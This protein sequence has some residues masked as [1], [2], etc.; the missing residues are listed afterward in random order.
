MNSAKQLTSLIMTVNSD[1]GNV[2]VYIQERSNRLRVIVGLR[3][4]MAALQA[5]AAVLRAG[6]GFLVM[7][8]QINA[9]LWCPAPLIEILTH[10]LAPAV[11]GPLSIVAYLIL[12]W[13]GACCECAHCLNNYT[14]LMD[15]GRDC[16]FSGYAAGMHA[17]M[18]RLKV[19]YLRISLYR[20]MVGSAPARKLH[21]VLQC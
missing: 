16:L 7:D 14:V 6:L 4:F 13:Q 8:Q 18:Q 21:L 15:H 20:E 1:Y 5:K 10:K 12:A 11:T 9:L 2:C 3:W 19:Q 17:N